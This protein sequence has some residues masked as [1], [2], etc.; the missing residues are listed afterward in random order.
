MNDKVVMGIHSEI[1]PAT[2]AHSTVLWMGTPVTGAGKAARPNT[3]RERRLVAYQ[4]LRIVGNG[5][6]RQG[7]GAALGCGRVDAYRHPPG[8]H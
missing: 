8:T 1:D 3:A 6:N 5:D 7:N 2:Q 4:Y